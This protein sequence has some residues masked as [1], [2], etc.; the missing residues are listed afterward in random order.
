[1]KV[2]YLMLRGWLTYPTRN[3]E[4]DAL[5]APF[6]SNALDAL[7]RDNDCLAAGSQLGPSAAGTHFATTT[8]RRFGIFGVA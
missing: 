5:F 2:G 1:M 8:G 7:P 4:I 6:D 3:A